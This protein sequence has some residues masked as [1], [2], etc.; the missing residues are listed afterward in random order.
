MERRLEG[1]LL[2]AALLTIP[3]IAIEQSSVGEPWDTIATRRRLVPRRSGT[4][5]HVDR[6]TKRG[7]GS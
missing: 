3:A 5:G 4:E 2:V 7:F 6:E 1:P